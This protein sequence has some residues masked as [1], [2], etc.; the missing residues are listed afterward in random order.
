MQHFDSDYADQI[1]ERLRRI[2]RDSAPAWGSLCFDTLIEHFIWTLHHAL[3]RSRRVPDCSTW[4]LRRVVKP[5]VLRGYIAIPKN[6]ALPAQLAQQGI[7]LCD[8]GDIETLAALLEEYLNL[9]Q[10]DDL[11]PAPHPFLGP[12]SID[13]W[14][15]IH[16][17]HF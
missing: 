4:F 12:L 3:G 1:I 6:I 5:L 10:A 8:A 14:D 9:V 2:P 13:D 7:T 17:L 16:V 15:R 11:A